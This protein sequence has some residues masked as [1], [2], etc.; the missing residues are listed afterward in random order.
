MLNSRM[1]AL[2][3]TQVSHKHM[4][5]DECRIYDCTDSGSTINQAKLQI[6]IAAY[7]TETGTI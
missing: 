2:G 3:Q 1:H 6:D 5:K 4:M 7:K